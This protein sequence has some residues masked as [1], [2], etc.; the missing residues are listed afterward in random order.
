VVVALGAV[1][2]FKSSVLFSVWR[3]DSNRAKFTIFSSVN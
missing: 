3:T 1:D 2:L